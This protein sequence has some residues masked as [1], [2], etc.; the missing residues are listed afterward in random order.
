MIL[1]H[2]WCR[3]N[4]SPITFDSG[5]PS[6]DRYRESHCPQ[7]HISVYL[8][9]N[10]PD[11]YCVPYQLIYRTD[12]SSE[13]P[14]CG[15]HYKVTCPYSTPRQSKSVGSE[16]RSGYLQGFK[17]PTGG[18]DEHLGTHWAVMS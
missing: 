2:Q 4:G 8:Q 17:S 7:Q 3:N 15:A 11:Q 1:Q 10:K 18:S 6:D 12:F 5:G 16:M 9:R 13:L 14:H